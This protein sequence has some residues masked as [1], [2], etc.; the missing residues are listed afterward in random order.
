MKKNE[1]FGL[2]KGI[3]SEYDE[4]GRCNQSILPFEPIPLLNVNVK[5]TIISWT[6]QVILTQKFRNNEKDPIE[7]VYVFF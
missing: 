3:T 6:A 4:W 2:F 1:R 7:A 5:V